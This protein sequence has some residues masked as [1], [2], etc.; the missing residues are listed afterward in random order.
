MYFD[1][2]DPLRGERLE[3][4]NKDG[5]LDEELRPDVTDQRIFELYVKMSVIRVADRTALN[6]QREG[7]MGTYAPVWGQEA[8]QASSALLQPGDWL[9][10]SYREHGAM[11]LRGVPLSLIYRYWMGEEGGSRMP[12]ELNVLPVSIP[13]GSQLLHG[14][15][16]AW[17]QKLQGRKA[18]AIVYFGD[19]ATSEGEALEALNF[20][21]VFAT[22]TVFFCQNNQYAISVPR[23]RQTAAKTIAQKAVAFG[24]RG[25]QIY[26]NDLLAVYGA[27]KE[28]LDH[29]R[30][31]GGPSLI[32]ALT[33]RFGPHTTADD[34]TKYR[35][36]EERRKNEPF[37]PLLRLQK[38]LGAKGLWSEEREAEI[39]ARA[40][41]EVE[42][43]VSEAERAV[44]MVS[45]EAIF[46]FTYETLP[47][48]MRRQKEQ[49]L[50]LIDRERK[51]GGHG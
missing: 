24:F 26:G 20:A 19:G 1:R 16:V 38:Y 36:D 43:A 45:P 30:A 4:L 25:I 37:D 35:S 41:E 18:A 47:P 12:V 31:G 34:P 42:G 2:F 27:V 9:V 5:E 6:L 32:E 8:C 29:A 15:G 23:A 11:Y 40:K 50:A 13:V 49:Y 28:A 14:V 48:Y 46:D 22:P 44:E 3:I 10:P 17:A 7:R 39:Q 33:Y 51:R 21:G